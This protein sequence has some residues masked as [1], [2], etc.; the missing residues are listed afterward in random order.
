MIG[1]IAFAALSLP[2]L[3]FSRRD[4]LH[5]NRHGF[6]RFFAYEA[7]LGLLLLNLQ[8]WFDDPLSP[9][10]IVS[11]ALLIASL[12]LAVHGFYLLKVIGQPEGPIEN[13]TRLVIVGAYRFIRHPLYA[14]LILFAWGACLKH[15]TWVNFAL[16]LAATAL[17]YLTGRSEEQE[18]LAR[19][20]Q[21]YADYIHKTRMFIPFIF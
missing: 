1:W 17:L 4:L 21:E 13:T 5:P 9:R 16:A 3:I 20:G 12:G 18:N 11:W 2:V 6:Y 10:Q 19:F 15:V 8:G 7:I 14:S